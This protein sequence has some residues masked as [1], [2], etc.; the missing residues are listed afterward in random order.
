LKTT[1]WTILLTCCV[2]QTIFAQKEWKFKKE[3]KG[4]KV[5]TRNV[6]GSNL[7]ELKFTVTIESSLSSIIALLMD[8]DAYQ[9]WVFKCSKSKNLKQVDQ[10]TTI[11]Y[12]TVDFPWPFNDRELYAKATLE[13]DPETKVVTTINI[14]L[15]DY[16]PK[17]ED[18][19]RIVNHINKWIFKP[20]GPKKVEATYFLQSEPAGNIPTW[21]VNLA[22]DQG[23]V[24]S[25][26]KFR[27]LLKEEKYQNAKLDYI[28]EYDD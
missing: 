25:M 18:F 26:K 5:Y 2:Q 11:D 24:K 15:P 27:V 28:L 3:T 9:R 4:I 7:K 20:V 22:I 16:A 21:M 13:Q 10:T 6:E 17:N 1:I 23:P 14:G 19:I 12:Y 8:V